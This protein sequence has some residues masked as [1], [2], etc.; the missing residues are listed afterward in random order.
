MGFENRTG[1][2]YFTI[3]DGKFAIKVEKGTPN[4]KDRINKRGAEVSEVYHD[5]FAGKLLDIRT[6]D[7]EW[8]KTWEFDFQDKENVY[9]LSLPYSN[10]S[11]T[12]ILKMLPNVDLA[13]EMKLQVQQKVE[14]GVKKTSLFIS[15]DGVT[16]KHAYTK[17]VPNG[18]PPMEQVMVK[19][20][21][22]WDDTKRIQFLH[23]MVEA[24]ILPKLPRNA[25]AVVAKANDEDVTADDVWSSVPDKKEE[26]SDDNDF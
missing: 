8:G 13:K 7:G 14:D 10:G 6:R 3:Y 18:L 20:S 9:T 4:S 11:S 23:E 16:L 5:S 21:L 26:A 15:Q 25:D 12:A 24:D 1:G 22:V 17:D 2:K 19:G